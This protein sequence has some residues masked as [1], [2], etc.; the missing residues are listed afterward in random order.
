MKFK[1][2]LQKVLEHRKLIE[3]Q[4]Q[5]DFQDAM[6]ELVA[7]QKKLGGMEALSDEARVRAFRVQDQG[8]AAVPTLSQ[9]DE[10]I[11]NQK[12]LIERL[13]VKIQNQEK[14]VEEKREILRQAAVE[15]KVIVKLKERRL[16]EFQR[17]ADL[18]EQKE[19][20]E[21]SVLRYETPDEKEQNS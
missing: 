12:I 5:K 14:V 13:K 17:E 19:M 3:N 2:P 11:K 1:F 7:L 20:D 18:L 10:F 8:G 16:E 15:T 6:A 21:Q 4:K 9:I